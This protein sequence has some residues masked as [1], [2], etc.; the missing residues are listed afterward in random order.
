MTTVSASQMLAA[1]IAALRWPCEVSQR[2][3][4]V[5]KGLL[6]TVGTESYQVQVGDVTQAFYSVGIV[7]LPDG[8]L[9]AMSIG[10][11]KVILDPEDE[12][13]FPSPRA[14]AERP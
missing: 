3:G 11:I 5:T 9:T 2:D 8:S 10:N 1:S 6:L 4:S 12:R 7:L 14:L 13:A